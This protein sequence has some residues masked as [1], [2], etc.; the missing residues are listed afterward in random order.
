[1]NEEK[2]NMAQVK[3]NAN[4]LKRFV[5]VFKFFSYF[6]AYHYKIHTYRKVSIPFF[7]SHWILTKDEFRGRGSSPLPLL[8]LAR[9]CAV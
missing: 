8:H 2:T 7:N 6:F 4:Y 9:G 5:T 3:E 1:M